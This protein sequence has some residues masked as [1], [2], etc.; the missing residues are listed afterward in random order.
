V[1]GVT[2]QQP[3]VSRIVGITPRRGRSLS[4]AAAAFAALLVQASRGAGRRAARRPAPAQ[5]E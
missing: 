3:D 5:P 2:L 1:V 4:P